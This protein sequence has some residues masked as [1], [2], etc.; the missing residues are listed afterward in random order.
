MSEFA[1]RYLRFL[2]AGD[3]F[4]GFSFSLTNSC[5]GVFP[6]PRWALRWRPLA[7]D[8]QVPYAKREKDGIR[9]QRPGQHLTR[10]GQVAILGTAVGNPAIQMATLD[11]DLATS[12]LGF[13]N[14]RTGFGNLQP[15]IWQPC[16][17]ALP[18]PRAERGGVCPA[19]EVGRMSV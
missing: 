7:P 12:C 16:S 6:R 13:G 8:L 17:A 18:K 11:G 14:P 5:R 9:L 19:L 2:S 1:C 15:V 4:I 3:F 10:V